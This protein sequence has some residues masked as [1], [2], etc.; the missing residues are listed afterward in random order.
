MHLLIDHPQLKTKCIVIDSMSESDC[1]PS[2]V[3]RQKFYAPS[4]K[5]LAAV[6]DLHV[7]ADRK[8]KVNICERPASCISIRVCDDDI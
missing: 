4:Y 6:M 2:S 8:S 3:L 1:T 5:S 7:T